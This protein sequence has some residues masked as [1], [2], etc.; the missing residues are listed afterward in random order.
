MIYYAVIDTN[1][2]LSAL[3]SKKEDSAT[4]K[5]LDAVFD[6]KITPLYHQDILAEY[7]EVLHREKFH[8]REDLIQKV[9]EAFRQYGIEVFPQPTGS[10]LIDMDD[11]VFYEVAMEKRENDA[12]L[13]TGNQKHYPLRDFIVTPAE[14]IAIIKASE[15]V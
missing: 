15:N 13:V 7:N 8:L 4:V 10:I 11:L 3:L 5:V 1:V 9:I 14:M 6:G 2:L 12:Y